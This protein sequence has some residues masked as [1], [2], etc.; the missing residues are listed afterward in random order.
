MPVTTQLERQDSTDTKIQHN[1]TYRYTTRPETAPA[2][3]RYYTEVST[4]TS[5]FVDG[6]LTS[7]VVTVGA[8]SQRQGSILPPA[9]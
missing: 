7:K 1:D 3:R 5:F 6:E 4:L 8:E 2:P 9:K